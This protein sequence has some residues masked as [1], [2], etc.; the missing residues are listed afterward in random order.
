[1]AWASAIVKTVGQLPLVLDQAGVCVSILQISMQ[2]YARLLKAEPASEP[3]AS[4][5]KPASP[6]DP[7][8]VPTVP[9]SAIW[10][11][12]WSRLGEKERAL[13]QLCSLLPPHDIPVRLLQAGKRD[14]GWM[15]D[16][17]TVTETVSRLLSF[18]LVLS[19]PDDSSISVPPVVHAWVRRRLE[20]DARALRDCREQVVLMVTSSLA[21]SSKD[22]DGDGDDDGGDD[23][24]PPAEPSYDRLVLPHLVC[25]TEIV[26]SLFDGSSTTSSKPL[27]WRSREAVCALARAYQ[28]L[29][30]ADQAC[31]L[32]RLA[33]RGLKTRAED[34]DDNECTAQDLR[35]MDA[36][37]RSL[38]GQGAH[39]DALT[40]YTRALAG[41]ERVPGQSALVWTVLQ[42]MAMLCA[43]QGDHDGAAE[44]YRRA[45]ALQEKKYGVRHAAVLA[46]RH[47]LARVLAQQGRPQE[48]LALLQALLRARE[49]S[50][51]A[52]ALHPLTLE[53]LRSMADVL[54]LQ[55]KH[56][57][58]LETLRTVLDRRERTLGSGHCAVLEM[59]DAI[60]GLYRRRRL[61]A[62]ALDWYVRLLDGLVVLFGRAAGAAGAPGEEGAPADA[63]APAGAARTEG[64][65]GAAGA[66]GA[67]AAGTGAADSEAA[68]ARVRADK[69]PWTLATVATVADIHLQLGRYDDAEKGY[70]RAQAG[71]AALG[72][73]VRELELAASLSAALC[74]RG[75]YAEA[76][77]CSR[78]AAK[79]LER[80]LGGDHPSALAATA[81]MA[82]IQHQQGNLADALTGCQR[83]LAMRTKRWGP[84]HATTLA[85]ASALAAVLADQGDFARAAP[86]FVSTRTAQEQ[87][88]G[89]SHT[90]VLD[91]VQG[92][93]LLLAELG[94]HTE[95][96]Q[97]HR[98]M[99][100][101]VA[102]M[103]GDSATGHPA[104][105]VAIYHLATSLE[106]NGLLAEAAQSYSQA[107]AALPAAH[108]VVL[109]ATRG[110]GSVHFAAQRFTEAH[111]L[112]VRAHTGLAARLG[113]RHPETLRTA[114]ALAAALLK[115]RR[116]PDAHELCTATLRGCE[117]ALGP[118][119]PLTLA[120]V[121][122]LASVC[123]KRRRWSE[124]AAGYRRARDGRERLLGRAHPASHESRVAL[125]RAKRRSWGWIF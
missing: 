95:A 59:V 73:A 80:R 109:L 108:P 81:A 87:L 10:E 65:A 118:E 1:M 71:F 48:A 117:A 45:L 88:L 2:K 55:G 72:M 53:T 98:R 47:R 11:L 76:L 3:P 82:R 46:T 40:W 70:R 44:L 89:P 79:S 121:H 107:Q 75:D 112:L 17:E 113:E 99:A 123:R 26:E 63:G 52:G 43:D 29:A 38:A 110:Q 8:A 97:L 9:A 100:T 24:Q 102:E 111:A 12:S 94:S 90:D 68:E 92:H 32:Y 33:L 13:L 84:Q 51:A 106:R 56:A 20:R 66:V 101:S 31:A 27:D 36:L 49:D 7:Q 64:A 120:A 22:G 42:H 15:L 5:R 19:S 35:T 74:G 77:D 50:P 96:L 41:A 114:I 39:A 105:A 124:A 62:E 18:S 28:R 78:T 6:P 93:A 54:E 58:A 116:L 122:G 16:D 83:V 37:G 69:Q 91:T 119:H 125:A 60:A 34:D 67:E 57:E 103:L 85:A 4:N 61:W 115:L 86:L 104:V 25:C 21:S 30:D 14:V 23:S